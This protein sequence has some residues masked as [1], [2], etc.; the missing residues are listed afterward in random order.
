MGKGGGDSFK[1]FMEIFLTGPS[2][3]TTKFS[4]FFLLFNMHSIQFEIHLVL[5][6]TACLHEY[7]KPSLVQKRTDIRFTAYTGATYSD[8]M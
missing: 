2:L 4:F 6:H 5:R 3:S 8:P 7:I 1:V